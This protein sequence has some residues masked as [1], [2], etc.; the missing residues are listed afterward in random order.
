VRLS[1]DALA[2][3]G[4]ALLAASGMTL[5]PAQVVARLLVTADAMGH[6]THGLA[7]LP[8]YAAELASGGMAG[9]G[10]PQV[11]SDR[12][13]AV[14]WDGGRLSGVWLTEQALALA[15]DRARTH[16]LAAVAIRKAHHIACL[17]AFLPAA[18]E[19][20]MMAIIASSDPSEAVVAPAGGRTGVF[21][22]D[23]IAVAIPT[24]GAPILIDMSASI[25]TMGMS[26]RLRRA[27]GRFPDAWALSANGAPTD[28]PGA[29]AADPPGVLLPTGGLDHG[30]KGYGLALMVEALTQGLAGHGRADGATQWGASVFVQAIDPAAFGG[31]AA[32]QRQAAHLAAQCLA[33]APIDPASPVRL[34]GDR[35]LAGLARAQ[36]E[37]LELRA[38]V[39][40][41]L[42]ALATQLGIGLPAAL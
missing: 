38:D 7:Q 30:H 36:A 21:T 13:A 40:V 25:T 11:V 15:I 31:L 34:P 33:S 17:A 22:P 24:G 9:A 4:A 35:A 42:V 12:G 37:G 16:G 19:A 23:P 20:G 3:F 10:A 41:E 2:D 32:F 29:L 18:I 1:F 6:T 14:V 27:G 26:A 8:D 28:D 5:E 39:W